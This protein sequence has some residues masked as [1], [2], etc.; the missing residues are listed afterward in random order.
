MLHFDFAFVV[1]FWWPGVFDCSFFVFLPPLLRL[2]ELEV[3][4]QAA[5]DL[6][7]VGLAVED[8]LGDV[9]ALQ[10]GGERKKR[11]VEFKFKIS[12][13]NS[14]STLGE[15]VRFQ[16]VCFVGVVFPVFSVLS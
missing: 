12:K 2:P 5:E 10:V 9:G 15:L 6:V 13:A 1:S 16:V 11:G 8:A 7:F 3:E 14:S 4:L